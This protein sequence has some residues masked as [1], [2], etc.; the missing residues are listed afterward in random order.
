ME[1]YRS[2][3]S[4]LGI[5]SCLVEPGGFATD[6]FGKLLTPSDTSRDESYGELVGGPKALFEAFEGALAQ[7]PE[8]NPQLVADAVAALVDD[9]HGSR[10][11]RTP[12]D[13]M[14][15]GAAIGPTN[16]M[17][18]GVTRGIYGNFGLEGM[19]EVKG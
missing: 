15:M 13:N 10:A 4:N 17:L 12:V 19:L 2:E 8:Q 3:L 11:F 1:N 18:E 6:F 7:N 9:E 16:D 5:E 14:G